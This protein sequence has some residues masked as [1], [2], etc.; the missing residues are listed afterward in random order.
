MG[1]NR[2]PAP[3][4]RRRRK[5]QEK[6]KQTFKKKK[7]KKKNAQ[8]KALMSSRWATASSFLIAFA[9]TPLTLAMQR[10]VAWGLLRHMD[11][12]SLKDDGNVDTIVALRLCSGV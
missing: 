10:V 8:A 6:V 12:V 4:P 11:T 7:K 3:S 2:S 1:K 5:T 9:P